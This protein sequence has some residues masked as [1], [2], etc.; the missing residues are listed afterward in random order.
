MSTPKLQNPAL[1]FSDFSD[2]LDFYQIPEMPYY[3]DKAFAIRDVEDLALHKAALELI[4]DSSGM[5]KYNSDDINSELYTKNLEGSIIIN[6]DNITQMHDILF[7]N[8]YL[9]I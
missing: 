5:E 7:A 2:F 1:N 8:Q 6:L 3:S 4:Y 9:T